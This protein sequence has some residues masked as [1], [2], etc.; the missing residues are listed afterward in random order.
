[1]NKRYLHLLVFED[2]PGDFKLVQIFLAGD[3][4]A[5][6][7][8]SQATTFSD[9]AKFLEENQVDVILLDLGLPD[10]QGMETLQKLDP[11][12]STIPIIVLTCNNDMKTAY[13][14]VEAGAQDF[15][16]KGEFT[17]QILIRSIRYA[18]KRKMADNNLLDHEERLRLALDAEKQGLFD[19]D[20]IT[21]Q[22]ITDDNYARI[23]NYNPADFVETEQTWLDRIHPDDRDYVRTYYSAFL[24]QDFTLFHI[25]YRA[26]TK[27]GDWKW[28]SITGKML[29]NKVGQP[30]RFIG[31]QTDINDRK[32]A[33]I[34]VNRLFQ[35]SHRRLRRI[36]SLQQIDTSI[37]SDVNYERTMLMIIKNVRD[38]LHSDAAAILLVDSDGKNL[39][40]VNGDG[41]KTAF[42]ERARLK[43]GRGLAGRVAE[44]TDVLRF[45][46]FGN[47][48]LDPIFA[49]L[50]NAEGFLDYYGVS[51]RVKDKLIGVLELYFRNIQTQDEEWINYFKTLSG[52]AAIAIDKS[53]LITN[54]ADTNSEL[55]NAYDATIHGWS[56]ALDLRDKETEG[57]TRRVAEM[58][59]H[60]A[61]KM[62]FDPQE[63][64][65]IHRGALLHDI[66]KMGVP[67]SI[68]Q[69][70]GALMRKNGRS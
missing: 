41:F 54:L 47:L 28:I 35:E 49:S 13:E 42:T 34:E 57:H 40:Y 50:L 64:V 26:K 16:I 22:F 61:K 19:R 63:I 65:H 53:R 1:M 14:A 33:A 56:R 43:I 2:N 23:L 38:Q 45:L 20:L 8:I 67:D 15:L 27:I 55:L 6:F 10:S 18:V 46:Q 32:L 52:V 69:K 59:I 3:E 4:S 11:L 36:E 48:D 39:H 62:E 44:D 68:L 51:L 29:T 60:L 12:G 37:N 5:E 17:E 21:G 9:G 70:P 25:E 66:G 58:T 31:I 30:T 7:V 24:N